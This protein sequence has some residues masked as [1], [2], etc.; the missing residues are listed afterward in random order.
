MNAI[1]KIGL[2]SL[3]VVLSSTAFAHN[4]S[5]EDITRMNEGGLLDYIQLGAMHMLSGYDH[6][7]FLF[8]VM[9]FLTSFK[10]IAKFVTAFTLGHCI[11]LVFA[12]YMHITFNYFLVD[13]AIAASVIYKGFDNNDGFRRWFDMNSPNQLLMVFAFGLLHGFGLS[14][15]LQQLPIYSDASSMLSKILSFNVGVELGQIAALVPMFIVLSL[16]RKSTSF[17]RLS[18]ASN[19]FLIFAGVYLL[20][21]QLHRYEHDH[22]ARHAAKEASIRMMTASKA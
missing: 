11:T 14:T 22:D 5:P 3:S 4:I 20:F 2:L 13:A 12:T 9:F 18:L 7:L 17:K 21:I 6:L 15:R 1:V 8:G 16:A 10:D 19:T